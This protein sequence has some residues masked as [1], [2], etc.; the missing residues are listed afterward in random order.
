MIVIEENKSLKALNTFGIDA[1]AR[2]FCCISSIDE[3]KELQ[4][5]AIYQTKKRLILG[6]GSNLLFTKD[7]DGLVLQCNPS[8]SFVNSKLLPPPKINLFFV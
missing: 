2:F 8:K 7:F 1:T 3:L 6:G 4:R 5:N